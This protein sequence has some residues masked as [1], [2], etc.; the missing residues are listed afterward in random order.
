MQTRQLVSVYIM[1]RVEDSNLCGAFTPTVFKTAALDHSANP[2]RLNRVSPT[3]EGVGFEP[4]RG[5]HLNGLAI[6]RF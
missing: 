1:R 6:R 5:F 2:P 4:T 3:A